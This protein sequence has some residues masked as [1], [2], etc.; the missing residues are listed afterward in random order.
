[1]QKQKPVNET[2]DQKLVDS[3]KRRKRINRIKKAII[4]IIIASIII[5]TTLCIY[6]G[7]K[8]N[9]LQRQIKV[10]Q[11]QGDISKDISEED[12]N[13]A[14]AAENPPTISN[15]EELNKIEENYFSPAKILMQNLN[16]TNQAEK[17]SQTKQ[18]VSEESEVESDTVEIMSEEG[19]YNGKTVYLT[20]DDGPSEYTDDILDLLDQY[21]VKATFFV[22]GKTDDYSKEMYQRIIDEGHG[23]GMHSYSHV[24]KDIYNSL[25]DFDKDFTKLWNLLYDTTGYKPNIF[26]FP[27]GSANT[28]NPNGMDEF[29]KYLNEKSIVYFDWNVVNGDETGINYTVDELIDNVLEGVKTKKRSIVL[30]HDSKDRKSTIDSLPKLLEEL[31]SGGAQLLLLDETVAPIQQIKADSVE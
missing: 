22:V 2:S 17:Q 9:H 20:F 16:E 27:G 12:K 26:R 11:S 8:V 25:E 23:L 18:T 31:T 21:H 3:A 30:M 4:F 10:L 6:L 1:M 15:K 29:I 7:F 13:Y 19:I 5:P 28:V 14:Y 24:Y